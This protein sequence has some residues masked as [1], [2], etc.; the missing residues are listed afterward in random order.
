M[1]LDWPPIELDANS[2]FFAYSLDKETHAQ[3]NADYHSNWQGLLGCR[4]RAEGSIKPQ[5]EAAPV[6][7]L[8]D[9]SSDGAAR[10]SVNR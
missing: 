7:C 1:T 2:I 9:S 8:G 5:K 3:R 10:R 4:A 6:C